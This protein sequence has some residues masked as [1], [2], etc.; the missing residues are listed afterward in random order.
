[1]QERQKATVGGVAQWSSVW[2][3]HLG[4]WDP[5]FRTQVPQKKE[6]ERQKAFFTEKDKP[7]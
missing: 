4:L 2:L 3:Y 5:E 1:M 6:K 7:F